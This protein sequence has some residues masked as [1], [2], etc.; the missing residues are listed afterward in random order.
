M[1][2]RKIFC[3]P[4]FHRK[5]YLKYVIKYLN[6]ETVIL[7]NIVL[8]CFSDLLFCFFYFKL[9]WAGRLH[10]RAAKLSTVRLKMLVFFFLYSRLP[11]N[12]RRVLQTSKFTHKFLFSRTA[13][14]EQQI[15]VHA[16]IA[17]SLVKKTG[18]VTNNMFIS[19]L[20]YLV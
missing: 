8:I 10:G 20:R 2:G 9:S 7:L 17:A 5:K 18:K 19:C 12:T 13:S 1:F 6:L 16:E 3:Y 14:R 4:L 15:I 11:L